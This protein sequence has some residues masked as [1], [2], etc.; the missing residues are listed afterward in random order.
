VYNGVV[1][2]QDRL[3]HKWSNVVPFV[4]QSQQ[5]SITQLNA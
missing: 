3:C 1:W 2:F 4:I 5:V